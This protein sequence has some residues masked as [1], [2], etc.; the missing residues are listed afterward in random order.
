VPSLK[1][2]LNQFSSEASPTVALRIM[3]LPALARRK[4]VTPPA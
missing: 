1:L 2:L 4:R 3:F